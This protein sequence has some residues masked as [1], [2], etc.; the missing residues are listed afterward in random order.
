ML[1]GALVFSL[2]YYYF[3]SHGKSVDGLASKDI[4]SLVELNNK[5]A[6]FDEMSDFFGEIAERK[7]GVYAFSLMKNGPLPFGL[8][9]HLLG[10]TVGDILYEQEGIEGMG[11]CT[12]DF[13]NACSHTMVIGSLIEY[14]ESAM[15]QIRDACHNAP[16]GKGAY[17]MCFHGLGHGVLAFNSYDMPKAIAMCQEFGTE[18]FNNRE[19]I[20][21]FGGTV[22]EI[23]GGGGHDRENWEIRRDEYLQPNDPFGFCE[24]DMVPGEFRPMC[25]NYM[26]PYVFETLDADMGYPAPS[27]YEE[28]FSLCA[29]IPKSDERERRECFGGLGKEFIGIAAGRNY[30][31]GAAPT[32]GQLKTMYSWCMLAVPTDGQRYCLE[33]TVNS[34]YWGG[35]QPVEIPLNYCGIVESEN[36]RDSCYR[37]LIWNVGFYI[38]EVEYKENF[39]S[40]LPKE[41]REVC[42]FE[43]GL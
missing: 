21:C 40:A 38:E 32:I 35:E 7:G 36:L 10:H 42:E 18:E 26:T 5:Q 15:P 9:Q 2:A 24:R 43:I 22:M 23:I 30:V 39:C 34:L 20:E 8:D 12:H 28:T 3:S 27:V 33:S 37:N 16:G 13:R 29:E 14:G 41:Y 4:Q 17:T 11:L 25:Y 31:A 6:N 1:V 19:A